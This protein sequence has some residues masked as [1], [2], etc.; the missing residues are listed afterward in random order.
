MPHSAPRP[1]RFAGCAALV[2][3]GVLCD[4]HRRTAETYDQ[5]RASSPKRGYGRSWARLRRWVL[6]REP[7][8]QWPGCREPASQVD[9][10]VPL[11][12]GGANDIS[13]LQSLCA[14]HHSL[15]TVERDGGFG[16][17]RA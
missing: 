16:R 4:A 17:R 9:H 8:C 2:R 7:V 5:Q 10:I 1:C 11:S 12:R 13:N 3:S 14:H 15:K 6:A